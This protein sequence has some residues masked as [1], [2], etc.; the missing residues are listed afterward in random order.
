M[1][2]QIVKGILWFFIGLA[3]PVAV[4]RFV[5]G[6]GATTNLMDTTPWG[7]WIG[8]DVLAGVALAAGGFVIA[9][10]IYIFVTRA[11]ATAMATMYFI[12][13]VSSDWGFICFIY[14]TRINFFCPGTC[15]LRACPCERPPAGT[16]SDEIIRPTW[17]DCTGAGG[18]SCSGASMVGIWETELNSC[19]QEEQKRLSGRFSAEHF[20][21]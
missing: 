8:F 13:T 2:V 14:I 10:I 16:E 15:V 12:I 18:D 19:P 20:G 6:L 3:I 21:H 11:S 7:F 4:M 5:N 1:R 17:G 9:A